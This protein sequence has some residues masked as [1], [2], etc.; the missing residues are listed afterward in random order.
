MTPGADDLW[1]LPLGGTGE[2][3]MNL[4]LYG[5]NERWLMVD[6]GITFAGPDEPGP[7]IQM[8]DPQFIASRR[9]QL[10][11][12]IITHAHED[13]V[14]AVAHLW[15][16][17]RCPVYTTAFTAE[18]LR[19]KLAEA[20]LLSEV[21]VNVVSQGD[22]VQLD[23]FDVEWVGL[24]HST[25]ETQ[26]LVIRTPIANIFHTAD[27]KLDPQ[28]VV[29]EPFA[30][31]R[32]RRMATD[33]ILAMVCDSTNAL[34]D[35]HSVSEGALY[36]GLYDLV[37]NAPGRV[38]VACFGSNVA[39]LQTLAQVAEATGRYAGLLGRSLRNFYAAALAASVW[40]TAQRFISPGDLGYLPS[41]E[42]MAIATGSQGE[43]RAA[44][45]RLAAG[46]HPDLNLGPND[47]VIFSSRVIPGNETAVAT[48]IRRLKRFGV[49]VIEDNALNMPI[50]ASGHP[51]KDELRS[52]YQWVRPQIAIPVHGEPKHMAANAQI[53]QEVGIPQ[54]M[55]GSNGD[56]FMLAPQRGI[57]R[58]AAPVGRLGLDNN[59]LV[60]VPG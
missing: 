52:M 8:A 54:Q 34:E 56:L 41:T 43:P 5:H 37:R 10:S 25:P 1:F 11:A 59:R 2:I 29:G 30:E 23:V 21:P 57:R 16:Q 39:R 48:L 33:D 36:D 32:Y 46:N 19:R 15:R 55:V 49:R 31:A 47:T 22:R 17:L 6:C 13:H 53:A 26:S 45:D 38:I 4:N 58:A 18:I 24:T 27:W 7:H 20:G 14:G 35:G 60:T 9:Q 40:D 50:H 3:G 12:L 28:P 42:V 44:L 51:A